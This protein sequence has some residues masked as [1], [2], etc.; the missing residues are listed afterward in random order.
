MIDEFTTFMDELCQS[1]ASAIQQ[2]ETKSGE[3][4]TTMPEYFLSASMFSALGLQRAVTLETSVWQLRDWLAVSKPLLSIDPELS[5]WKVDLI[6]FDGHQKAPHDQKVWALVE[7]KNGFIDADQFEGRRSDRSKLLSI[8]NLLHEDKPH[9]ICCG[10]L[11]AE[12][13]EFHIR[14]AGTLGDQWFEVTCG[15]LPYSDGEAFFCARVIPRT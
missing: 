13:R 9:L 10:S 11:N 14:Q 8:T 5:R 1:G 3:P 4:Y 7:I 15:H 6:V 12:R 2:Y